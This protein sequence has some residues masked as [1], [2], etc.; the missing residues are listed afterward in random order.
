MGWKW[1][2]TQ[3]ATTITVDSLPIANSIDPVQDRLLIYTASATDIQGINRNVLLG[4]SSQPLGL[5]DSQSPQNKVFDNTNSLSILDSNLT[6]QDNGDATKQVKFQLSGITT[7]NTRTLTIPDASD[8]LVG[9]AVTQTLTNKTLTAPVIN[10]G[11]A[12]NI[13]LTVDTISGHTTSNSGIIYGITVTAGVI[14]TT[15]ALGPNTVTNTSIAAGALSTSKI[16]NP[17]KFSVYRNAAFNIPSSFGVITF[18]TKVFDTGTNFSTSTGLF[19][20]PIAGFYLFSGR[21]A[22]GTSS[23]NE[24]VTA[25]FKNGAEYADG[26]RG[27]STN[28]QSGLVGS[29]VTTLIQLALGDTIGLYVSSNSG[30]AAQAGPATTYLS[31]FLVSAT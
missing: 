17:Y 23:A 10:G 8:T 5:T 21:C 14:T 7:G 20:A 12:D 11:S 4:L 3:T 31:G 1:C 13:A 6:I 24:I 16:A 27:I 9:L 30:I 26:S 25:I 29:N 2:M 15:T 28:T 19:T 18:D 22:T